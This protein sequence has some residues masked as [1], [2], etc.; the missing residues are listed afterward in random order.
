MGASAT[1]TL[2]SPAHATVVVAAGY[3]STGAMSSKAAAAAKTT[4]QPVRLDEAQS[5]ALLADM[6]DVANGAEPLTAVRSGS[7]PERP[8][9]GSLSRRPWVQT[10]QLNASLSMPPG[11][12]LL[13]PPET[14]EPTARGPELHESHSVVARMAAD[15]WR[16]E[17]TGPST[18]RGEATALPKTAGLNISP[19]CAPEPAG[20]SIAP[21]TGS[22]HFL[23]A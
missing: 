8:L 3:A 6:P 14:L 17:K 12:P 1:S 7:P 23:A 16:K 10:A 4:S 15:Y 18:V 5:A 19:T 2:S 21:F 13:R 11:M 9:S 20:F 22:P